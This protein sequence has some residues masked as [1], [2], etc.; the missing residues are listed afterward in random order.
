MADD[1]LRMMKSEFDLWGVKFEHRTRG[2]GHIELRW[3]VSPYKPIRSHIVAKTPSDFRWFLNERACI[4]RL[5][6]QD[7]LVLKEEVEK[8]KPHPAG[9]PDIPQPIGNTLAKALEIP[10]PVMTDR[11]L[12]RA[13]RDDVA[14]L[15]D[16][17][18]QL[19]T[20]APAAATP[21]AAESATVEPTPAE[22]TP[23]AAVE[24]PAKRQQPFRSV[25]ILAC[26]SEG[27]NS[28]DAIAKAAGIPVK[29]A[30]RKLYYFQRKGE[31]ETS[32]SQ[33]RR[34]PKLELVKGRGKSKLTENPKSV[35]LTGKRRAS[36]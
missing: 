16:L 9:T 15:T 4:R 33:W 34:K 31:L 21:S 3:Q 17:V 30:Y 1:P 22:P 25:N 8:K 24:A 11:E 32:N 36:A 23:V 18:L 28:I 12:L 29:F 14:V 2:S 5:F 19:L 13:L 20:T 6:R 10:Q 26:V 35:R 7:G 27:W